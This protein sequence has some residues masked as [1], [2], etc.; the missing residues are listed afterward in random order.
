MNK[1]EWYSGG[2]LMWNDFR[3]QYK[4]MQLD[5]IE[6]IINEGASNK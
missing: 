6:Q 2:T 4:N 5:E 1:K 3:K